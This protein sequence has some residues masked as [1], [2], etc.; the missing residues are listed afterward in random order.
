[1]SKEDQV[2]QRLN[3]WLW[4]DE[5]DDL[6]ISLPG[7]LNAL[8]WPDTAGTRAL[9]ERLARETVEELMPKANIIDRP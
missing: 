8:G 6:H 2:K 1:M 9:A 5:N 4:V 3:P 7:L